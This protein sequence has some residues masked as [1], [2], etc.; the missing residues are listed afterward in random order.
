MCLERSCCCTA[1]IGYEHRSLDFHEALSIQITTDAADD[2]RTFDEC[3]FYIRVHDQVYISLTV[4]GICIGQSV[5]FFRKHL[6][7]LAQ[8]RYFCRMNG[9]FSGLCLKY[10]AFDADDITHVVFF[11]IFVRLFA[12]AVSC[13]IG[14]DASLQI[15]N[16]AERSF[17]HDTFEH[18]TT[19]DGYFFAFQLIKVLFDLHAVMCH[20]IFCNLERVFSVLL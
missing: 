9:D 1:C 15:L 11:E 8:Q 4:T 17:S 3:I 10:F 20:I 19:G 14:L 6:E 12:N 2:F 18:H 16:V 13:H 7:T 5:E